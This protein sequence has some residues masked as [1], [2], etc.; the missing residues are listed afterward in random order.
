VLNR[1]KNTV[2]RADELHSTESEAKILDRI[3]KL[4][5]LAKNENRQGVAHEM[6]LSFGAMDGY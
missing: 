4:C 5:R 6:D 2:G 1:S 3:M